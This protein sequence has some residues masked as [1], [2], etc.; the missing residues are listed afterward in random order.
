MAFSFGFPLDDAWIF[1]VFAKNLATGYGFSFNP[2][3]PVLGTTSLLW[4]LV[5]AGSYLV[6]NSVVFISKFW[7]V[8]FSLGAVYLTYRI[9]LLLTP[10]KKTAFLG[11]LTFALVPP[12]I[13]GAVSGMEISLATFLFCLTLFFHL[14][15]MGQKQK[16]FFA[17][18]FGAL[19]FIA[20]PE[21]ILLYPLL[22]VHDY[23]NLKDKRDPSDPHGNIFTILKKLVVFILV[24]L[25]AIVLSY[26]VSGS[27]LP[28]TF[29]AKTLDSG[30]FWAVKNGNLP[31]LFISLF[32]NPFIW[33]GT[34]LVT[35]VCLNVF[36]A[37]FWCMGFVFS[38]L[39]N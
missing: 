32:L 37:F 24:L 15:E 4:V 29:A 39:F 16:T 36:W 8:I 34:M 38:A 7:G 6:T 5:L 2:G 12:I 30:L 25:P 35:L 17:P 18:V 1:W 11:V 3:E 14:K 22:L 23:V 9:C 33:G 28:N 19:C 27:L 10:Q 13:F 31:V 20:R 26:A 21:L